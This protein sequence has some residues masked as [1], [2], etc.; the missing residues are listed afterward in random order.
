[1]VRKTPLFIKKHILPLFLWLR[2][3]LL[4]RASRR[5]LDQSKDLW[6][7]TQKINDFIATYL[8]DMNEQELDVV[9]CP[10]FACPAIKL[11]DPV[12][13]LPS[14]SYVAIHNLTGFPA[15][16]LPVTKENDRDQVR[17]K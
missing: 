3:P 11:N 10:S 14:V 6:L 12:K 13:L 7:S 4:S 17:L 8:D 9:L 5:G 16:V 2:S 1:M 15:G